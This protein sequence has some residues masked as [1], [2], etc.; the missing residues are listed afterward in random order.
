MTRQGRNSCKLLLADDPALAREVLA[1]IR[2]PALEHHPS[3]WLARQVI[4]PVWGT[5]HAE[6]WSAAMACELQPGVLQPYLD[7]RTAGERL[8]GM[9]MFPLP[10][11][12]C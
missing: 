6:A 1:C 10:F 7:A 9:A 8:P 5:A 12:A 11:L 2:P 3:G 4:D